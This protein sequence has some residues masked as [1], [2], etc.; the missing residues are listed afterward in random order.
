M[1]EAEIDA[2]VE[3]LVQSGAVAPAERHRI[4]E[5]L[6]A[7]RQLVEA[8]LGPARNDLDDARD[9]L[10]RAIQAILEQRDRWARLLG[11]VKPLAEDARCRDAVYGFDAI[12]QEFSAA[13]AS[14]SMPDG[15]PGSMIGRLQ[16]QLARAV[17]ELR[18]ILG[19]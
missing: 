16:E 15:A 11:A 12:F 5:V 7:R 9:H 8:R 4:E 2:Q 10:S 6:H 13:C 19:P 1:N 17:E 14:L 18:N 3:L